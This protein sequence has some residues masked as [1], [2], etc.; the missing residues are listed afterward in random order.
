MILGRIDEDF[1]FEQA[2]FDAFAGTEDDAAFTRRIQYV[3]EFPAP[4]EA[5][6]EM[7][8]HSMFPARAPLAPSIDFPFL[9]RQ[10]QLTGG[11]IRNV[12]IDAAFLAAADGQRITMPLLLKAVSRHL[13]KSGRIPS[14]IEFKQYFPLLTEP[15]MARSN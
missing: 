8:W 1:D 4:G 6:R 14:A 11:E 3:V 13:V 9:A 15:A 2:V 12:S 10:F 7:L 5:Y